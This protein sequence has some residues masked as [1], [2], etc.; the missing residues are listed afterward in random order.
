MFFSFAFRFLLEIFKFLKSRTFAEQ[1]HSR[2]ASQKRDTSRTRKE[3]TPQMNSTTQSDTQRKPAVANP[4]SNEWMLYAKDQRDRIFNVCK[5]HL[6]WVFEHAWKDDKAHFE[7]NHW[8]SGSPI[9]FPSHWSSGRRSPPSLADTPFQIIK[10]FEFAKCWSDDESLKQP[11]SIHDDANGQEAN[12]PIRA[13]PVFSEQG[14]KPDSGRADHAVDKASAPLEPIAAN[15]PRNDQIPQSEP[16][17]SANGTNDSEKK[18]KFEFNALEFAKSLV[19][20]KVKPWINDL[21]LKNKRMRFA[22]SRSTENGVSNFRLEDHVWIWM[23]LRCL[24][25][26]ELDAELKP[27]PSPLLGHEQSRKIT[28][29]D[30]QRNMLRRF[31]LEETFLKQRLLATSRTVRESRFLFR[32]RDTA[33]F[34]AMKQ[35]FFGSDHSKMV[36]PWINSIETQKLHEHNDDAQWENPLRY[37]LAM[38]MSSNRR[39]QMNHKPANRMFSEAAMVLLYSARSNGLFLGEFDQETKEP[40]MFSEQYYRNSYWNTC[41]E[42]P[43]ILWVYGKP[44]LDKTPGIKPR[45][46]VE[47]KGR[48]SGDRLQAAQSTATYV[49]EGV[50]ASPVQPLDGTT[51]GVSHIRGESEIQSKPESTVQKRA[52]DT[53]AAID[54]LTVKK[55]M[56]FNDFID[57]KSVVE[58]SDDW[59]YSF[60]DF[61]DFDPEVATWDNIK[62]KVTG[63]LDLERPDRHFST[64]NLIADSARIFH[65][66]FEKSDNTQ[67]TLDD[68][69]PDKSDDEPRGAIVD[70]PKSKQRR[71]GSP[72]KSDDSNMF[73]YLETNRTI[74]AILK[75]MRTEQMAK[76]RIIWLPYPNKETALLCYLG[77]PESQ[78]DAMM[79]FFDRHYSYEHY[80]FDDTIAIQNIWETELHLPFYQLLGNE[81]NAGRETGFLPLQQ[82]ITSP[83]LSGKR[84]VRATIGFRF[85]GDFLDRYWTCHI[86]E[87]IPGQRY[88][89]QNLGERTARLTSG[90][91]TWKQRK[92]LELVLFDIVISEI[93]NGVTDILQ[94]LFVREKR[95]VSLSG[96]SRN[97]YLILQDRSQSQRYILQV[98][99]EDLK[100]TLEQIESWKNREADRSQERPRWTKNDERKY[101]GPINKLLRSNERKIRKLKNHQTHIQSLRTELLNTQQQFRDDLNFLGA[102]DIKYFTYVTVVFLP[103]GFAASIFSMSEAPPGIVLIS[104]V[105]TAVAAL[106]LTILALV[107]AKGIAGFV[108]A[109]SHGFRKFIGGITANS[110]LYQHYHHQNGQIS[111]TTNFVVD[112][113]EAV[114]ANQILPTVAHGLWLC[115]FWVAY[116]TQELPGRQFEMAYRSWKM[117]IPRIPDTSENSTFTR[118]VIS[119]SNTGAWV[120][121][122]PLKLGILFAITLTGSICW[123]AIGFKRLYSILKYPLAFMIAVVFAPLFAISYVVNLIWLNIYDTA[124]WS[125]KS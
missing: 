7:G 32:S 120:L 82:E 15:N 70:I 45:L 13:N 19:K 21:A 49:H 87:C 124:L 57:Q 121:L 23:A 27:A 44:S 1:S 69:F 88:D 115:W 68:E 67:A 105:V 72:G 52:R 95:Q 41:F 102:E 76:K 16:N 93:L 118:W 9:V 89:G 113:G 119:A 97:D 2:S 64:D 29:K 30:A 14:P 24:E 36:P 123:L 101:R 111:T 39:W 60:P 53:Q 33:L 43:Y 8:A 94:A 63:L 79:D 58:P 99:E 91:G 47:K 42:L 74:W 116:I 40:A 17:Q 4:P 75:I 50:P 78:H 59:L 22:F 106:A 25:E 81:S 51:E 107:S 28:S 71:K 114:D 98:L 73:W 108:S 109:L 65:Q 125:G 90:A 34:Y 80:F 48:K 31:T 20:S 61:L 96:F 110:V 26:F 77:S 112:Q 37:G 10:A 55:T 56:P 12:R 46:P 85:L 117:K 103:L 11:T 38:V 100:E 3:P 62:P 83:A 122:V 92:A 35:G 54:A 84:I 18:V 86:V 6:T 104:M 5:G 66:T